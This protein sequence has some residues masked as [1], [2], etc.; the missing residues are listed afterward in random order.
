MWMQIGPELTDCSIRS[1]L[2]QM[3][4]PMTSLWRTLGFFSRCAQAFRAVT[5][6]D[7]PQLQVTQLAALSLSC[8]YCH[9][10][11]VVNQTARCPHCGA[12]SGS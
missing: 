6:N 4:D 7:P 12:P 5:A 1:E 10:I 3:Y 9:A 2:H 8:R 11:H